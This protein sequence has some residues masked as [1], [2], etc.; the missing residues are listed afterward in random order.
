MLCVLFDID[1]FVVFVVDFVE[2]VI[3]M[4][5]NLV[6]YDCFVGIVVLYFDDVSVL[7]C[8]GYVVCVSGL[9]SDVWVEYF[10]IVLFI[11]E[12]GVFDGD[13][14]VCYIVWCDEFVVFVVFV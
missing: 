4:L 13:V 7:G 12:I 5:V 9:C 3:L 8:L 6:V 10:I 2:V 1:E 14:L 11:I